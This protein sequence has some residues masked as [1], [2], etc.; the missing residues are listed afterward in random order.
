MTP[1]QELVERFAD[2]TQI[3]SLLLEIY[4][5]LAGRVARSVQLSPALVDALVAGV[6]HPHPRVR[7]WCIQL[8]DHSEDPAAIAAVA[9]AL[10]DPV[11]RV[12]RNAAHALGCV[13]CKPAWDGSLPPGALDRLTE[14]AES[15]PNVK[16]RATARLSLACRAVASQEPEVLRRHV[17]FPT[18]QPG[19]ASTKAACSAVSTALAQ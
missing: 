14:L 15:D 6:R 11:P 10:D 17:K 3:P 9:P 1:E 12:R 16:V 2:R 5:T 4:G 19:V 18:R 13:I 7:W 8:L